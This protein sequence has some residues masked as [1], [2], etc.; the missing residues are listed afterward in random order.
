MDNM[1]K[2]NDSIREM[3]VARTS[4]IPAWEIAFLL[5]N[6]DF[7]VAGGCFMDGTPND[8]D[9][10]PAFGVAFDHDNIRKRLDS[11]KGEV[12]CESKNALTVKVKGKVVQ[13]CRHYRTTLFELVKSF[14]FSHCQV[15][16]E[17]KTR[18]NGDGGYATPL[19]DSVEWTDDW[20]MYRLN[21]R[22]SY[23]GS[24]YPLS[25]L[26]RLNKYVKRDIIKGRSYIVEVLKILQDIVKRGYIDYADFKDQLDAV[27]LLL[28]EPAE[29]NSAWQ[30][31]KACLGKG[32]VAAHY[33][34]EELDDLLNERGDES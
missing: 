29:S 25:S 6:D 14:D 19:V 34:S 28:L 15:G 4:R 18:E 21:G 27:D 16:V 17:Y 13:F 26:I 12:V 9:V 30:L 5:D 20:L 32:L 10:Y 24:E 23:T 11:L 33:T 31:F 8:Y 2:L 22:S 3:V 1:M 7:R